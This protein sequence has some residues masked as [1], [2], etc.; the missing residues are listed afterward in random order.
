MKYIKTFEYHPIYPKWAVDYWESKIE[1]FPNIKITKD[2][3]HYIN[4]ILPFTK[5]D[6]YINS[7]YYAT[8]LFIDFKDNTEKDILE[9]F[10]NFIKNNKLR[11]ISTEYFKK[12]NTISYQITTSYSNFKNMAELYNNMKKYNL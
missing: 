11:I 6:G 12:T 5:K 3:F 7:S 9:K 1:D 4:S 2:S 10:K 8:S